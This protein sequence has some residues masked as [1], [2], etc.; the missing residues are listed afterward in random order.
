MLA[1]G[2][3]NQMIP[4]I[5]LVSVWRRPF[6]NLLRWFFHRVADRFDWVDR[7]RKTRHLRRMMHDALSYEPN[8]RRPRTFNERM[9]WKIL[10]DRNPLIPRTLDKVAVRD[11]V[12]E[13]IGTETLVPLL[14]VWERA[15]DI[16][17]DDLPARF[18]LKTNHGSGY[19]ILVPDKAAVCRGS[20]ARQLDAWLV[21]NYYDRTGEWGYR[22]I[23]PRI[24][25][26]KFLAGA[27]G[28]VP[29]DYKL[30]VFGGRPRLLQ[31]HLDRFTERQRDFFYDPLTLQPI[32][33]GRLHHADHPDYAGP[34]AEALALNDLAARLGA[35]FDAVRIDFYLIEGQPQFGEVTHYSGGCGVPLGSPEQDRIIGDMWAEGTSA[36][37]SR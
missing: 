32:D 17:W 22:S 13:R 23:R 14:G 16:P 24:L 27:N 33:I 9:A 4:T 34:P 12:A 21:E 20:V 37:A 10:H 2:V 8:L 15:A 28:G 5:E 31:V 19:N 7:I 18:V 11:W 36:L 35:G 1:A 26:E 3:G 29:E 6:G 30:Y 25:A